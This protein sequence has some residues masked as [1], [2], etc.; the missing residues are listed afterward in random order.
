MAWLGSVRTERRVR[1]VTM[2]P[3]ALLPYS[4][5]TDPT[6]PS[7]VDDR[8]VIVFDGHCVLCS[9]FARFVV[10][11]DR[12]QVFRLLPAQSTLGQALYRHLHLDPV[13]FQ[14]NLLLQ[15]GR[16]W[17][18]SAG[19]LRMFA[20]LGWPWALA[21]ALRVVPAPLLDR[22]YDLVARNR[23]RWFGASDRCYVGEPA[24]GDRFLG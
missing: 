20:G 3:V 7:F 8:P 1:G 12:R 17:T 11:H 23:L 18:K 14:T 10:R 15:E 24:Q 5:R 21:G 9:G 2:S 19:T 6:V 13:N 16:A 4:Y 22:V